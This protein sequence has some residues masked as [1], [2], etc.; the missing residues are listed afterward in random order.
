MSHHAADAIASV[1]QERLS[2]VRIERFQ[3]RATDQP[4]TAGRLG[5]IHP[6]LNAGMAKDYTLFAL[7]AG[8]VYFDRDGRRINVAAA[9][10]A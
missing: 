6:G 1:H 4:P 3:G 8:T 9:E 10:S 5:R 7:A 2:A